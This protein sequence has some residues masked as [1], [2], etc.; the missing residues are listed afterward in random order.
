MER[1]TLQVTGMACDGCEQTVTDTLEE[2]EGVSSA[3]ADH[4]ADEVNVEHDGVDDA[5]IVSAI[6][7]A[8]YEAAD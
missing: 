1:T 6:E 5:T 2:L 4:E 7:D 3:T 8:G